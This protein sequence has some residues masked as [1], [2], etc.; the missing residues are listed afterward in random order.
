VG[1]V[2]FP[3]E[4]AVAGV[5]LAL[6]ALVTLLIWLGLPETD[7]DRY[8]TR[9]EVRNR[10]RYSIQ[11]EIRFTFGSAMRLAKLPG[12]EFGT[13]LTAPGPGA[14][15]RRPFSFLFLPRIWLASCS[16]CFFRRSELRAEELDR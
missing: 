4:W 5:G 2:G 1:F 11:D 6:V 9:Q 8:S 14:L 10:H 15:A 7:A 12:F 3:V 13:L 16:C